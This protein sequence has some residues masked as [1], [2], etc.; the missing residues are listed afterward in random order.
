MRWTEELHRQFVEAVECLGGQDGES[1]DT[2]PRLLVVLHRR[3]HV[4]H[5]ET[6]LRATR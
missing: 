4:T 1:P 3:V 6:C 5:D 2:F